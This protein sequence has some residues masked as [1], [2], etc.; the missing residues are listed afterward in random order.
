MRK[1]AQGRKSYVAES[2]EESEASEED[3]SEEESEDEEEESEDD[4]EEAPARQAAKKPAKAAPNDV[5]P[6]AAKKAKP[7]AA[8]EKKKG[9]VITCGI[10]RQ[11]GHNRAGC[12]QARSDAAAAAAGGA[13]QPTERVT[14]ATFGVTRSVNGNKP[15]VDLMCPKPRESTRTPHRTLTSKTSLTALRARLQAPSPSS[16]SRSSR[17]AGRRTSRPSR[18]SSLARG[19]SVR[20][21]SFFHHTFCTLRTKV[22]WENCAATW[23]VGTGEEQMY[24][25]GE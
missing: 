10:C 6:A 1:A 7:A 3:S 18:S 23:I 16:S 19:P 13:W 22:R 14:L 8:A 24:R 25:S 2:S 9:P 11:P 5:G 17:K 21:H 20:F 15:K 4:E 12:P